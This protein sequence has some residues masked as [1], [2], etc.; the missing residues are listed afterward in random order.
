MGAQ[1]IEIGGQKMAMLPVKDY[2]RLLELA[3]YK[4]DVSAAQAAEK[5]RQ[6]GEE[7]LPSEMVDRILD[8]ENALRVW[9]HHRGLTLKQLSNEAGISF[10]YLSDLERG[11][12]KGSVHL[13]GKLARALDVSVDDILPAN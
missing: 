10:N 5:R 8:G 9:R 4:S 6:Q 11:Q 7:Y 2:E 1:I 13:W 12:R 3:E